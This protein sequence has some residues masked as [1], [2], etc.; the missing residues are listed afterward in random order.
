MEGGD[1]QA[2]EEL[3]KTMC[4][5]DSVRW[6]PGSRPV[7]GGVV[8]G[9][10]FAAWVN[11]VADRTRDQGGYRVQLRI[12]FVPSHESSPVHEWCGWVRCDVSG[13]DDRPEG[14][15][16]RRLQKASAPGKLLEWEIR[17]KS[18]A[19]TFLR[20]A[21]WWVAPD[22]PEQREEL[23]AQIWLFLLQS[24]LL[25]D[26]S[27]GMVQAW[28][29]E[30]LERSFKMT[31]EE[32]SG[33]FEALRRNFWRPQSARAW[34]SYVKQ[35]RYRSP[36]RIAR[37]GTGTP[38]PMIS[39]TSSGLFTVVEAARYLELSVGTIHQWV[40]CGRLATVSS[41]LPAAKGKPITLIAHSELERVK[42]SVRLK[43]K[44]LVKARQDVTGSSEEAARKWVRRKLDAGLDPRAI[45]IASKR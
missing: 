4:N 6:L 31:P 21:H 29:W 43:M 18:E 17:K 45:L 9:D 41:Q 40:R 42:P 14:R 2:V 25:G 7:S 37:R 36:E 26:G 22:C 1:C 30:Y 8:R 19:A 38:R 5:L 16:A 35:W 39:R 12:R 15:F 23:A 44:G 13:R 10:S 3:S 20:T 11:P 32:A 24:D 33:V 27:V 28:Y 34:R